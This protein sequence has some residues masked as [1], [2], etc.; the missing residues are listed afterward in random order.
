MSSH[1]RGVFVKTLVLFLFQSFRQDYK[2]VTL[3]WISK[4]GL[5]FSILGLVISIIHHMKEK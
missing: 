2:Y 3:D 4:I 5:S 1:H